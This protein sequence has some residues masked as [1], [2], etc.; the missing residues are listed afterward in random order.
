MVEQFKKNLA[1]VKDRIASAAARAGRST[2]E[3]TLVGVTK[4][5]DVET[6]RL[7][8]ESGHM[9]LGEN[10]PQL[11]LEKRQALADLSIE[12]HLIGHLQR[13]KA[14]RMVEAA[15]LIHSVD[16]L[17]LLKA[18]DGHATEQSKRARVLLEVNVS[19]ES[20]KHGFSVEEMES[21]I[22]EA[23][24]LQAVQ[25]DGLMAMA[26]LAGNEDDARKEFAAMR[27]LSQR[28]AASGLPANVL[29][30][31]LSMGMSGDYEVAIEEGATIVRVG[32]ALL[33][34]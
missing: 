16:S 21:V 25:V 17:R 12:W 34:T 5:L 14:K 6:T 20:A 24:G 27:E 32:S 23:A 28:L 29:M 13:N 8:V 33:K 9:V 15:Q 11:L 2:D 10:R 26:G 31:E 3:I 1:E 30:S 19:G 4:Y 18:I 22:E 7:F